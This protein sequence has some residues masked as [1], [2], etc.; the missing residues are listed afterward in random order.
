MKYFVYK[1]T[2]L[3]NNKIYVGQTYSKYNPDMSQIYVRF[4]RHCKDAVKFGMKVPG[5]IDKAIYKYG[6]DNFK[7]ELIEECNTLKEVNKKEIYWIS[8]LN[9]TNR[10]IG[11]NLTKGGE[12]GDTYRLKSK[13]EMDEIKLKIS[14]SNKGKNNGNSSQV[15][16]MNIENGNV[17]EFETL[18]KCLQFFNIHNKGV[19]TDRCNHK[20]KYYFRKKWNFAFWNDDF[21]NDLQ[22]SKHK[23]KF[24]TNIDFDKG[25]STIPDECK[26]VEL[27]I[28]TNSE[29]E[30]LIYRKYN[31]Y[32]KEHIVS[33][34]SNSR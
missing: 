5:A 32:N 17:Y 2:N 31:L 12:G 14:N 7:V 33:P 26:G 30:A 18:G 23:N 27:E 10:N 15:K 16:A 28:S 24:D 1:I 25:V 13:E 9:S 11:Y 4:E 6:R 20:L 34:A 8:K 21:K 22:I 3:I 19:V 29:R